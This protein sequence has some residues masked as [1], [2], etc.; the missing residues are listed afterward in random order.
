MLQCDI[1]MLHQNTP[2]IQTNQENTPML[3]GVA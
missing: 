2:N 1:H 3:K